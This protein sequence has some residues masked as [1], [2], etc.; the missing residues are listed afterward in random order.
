M[1]AHKVGPAMLLAAFT[2]TAAPRAHALQ[3]D[4]TPQLERQMFEMVNAARQ[5]AV[6]DH[7]YEHS[8]E[9]S[10]VAR[11][12]SRDMAAHGFFN[13]RSPTTGLPEDRLFAAGV[14]V[15][16]AGENIAM[17]ATVREAMLKLLESDRHR[18]N[19]LHT[20]FT[21]VGIGIARAANG[22]LYVTQVFAKPPP[23]V[24]LRA[25][26]AQVLTEL[27]ARRKTFGRPPMRANATL[28]AIASDLARRYAEAG[29][30]VPA[31]ISA[32][33]KAGGFRH[34][35]IKSAHIATW[36]PMILANEAILLGLRGGRIG[37]GFAPNTKHK[38]L[39]CGQL[40]AV[41]VFR[42]E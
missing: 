31:D 35:R 23:A 34:E 2:L 39:G 27:N 36:E 22:L 7:L 9:L 40:W 1:S 41:V 19:L 32:A 4:D 11:A 25:L 18:K 42:E 15:M 5:V 3:F 28:S 26:P 14:G 8:R 21:H 16:Q 30:P 20:R 17:E 38:N 24:D 12:H 6:K 37:V 10:D 29:T 33:A 13:H